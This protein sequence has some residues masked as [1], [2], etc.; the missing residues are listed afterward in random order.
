MIRLKTKSAINVNMYVVKRFI[1]NTIGSVFTKNLKIKPYQNTLGGRKPPHGNIWDKFI[2]LEFIYNYHILSIYI[3][4]FLMVNYSYNKFF[5][6][7]LKTFKRLNLIYKI[8]FL[9][10]EKPAQYQFGVLLGW[11]SAGS[12]LF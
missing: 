7:Y 12:S 9:L 8:L 5:L 6:A 2:C 10:H 3:I 4:F 11:F 1:W